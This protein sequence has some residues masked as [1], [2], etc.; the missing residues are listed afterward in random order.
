MATKPTP[1]NTPADDP[2]APALDITKIGTEKLHVPIVGL[3]PLIVSKF[4][5]K[6]KRKMLDSQQGRKAIKEIRNPDADF[7]A[8]MY[9]FNDGYGFPAVAFKLATV[10]AARLYGK[11]VTMRGLLQFMFFHGELS[12]VE[13]QVLVRLNGEPKMR[14]DYVRLAGPSRGADLRYRA[15]FRDWSA[16]L[17]ITYVKSALSRESMLSLLDAGGLTVGVGEW[18]PERKGDFG[19][20]TIDESRKVEVLP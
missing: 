7:E 3:T 4:S 2:G 8:S 18:R 10:S 15:E 11:D 5:E 16:T 17:S 20:Y 14:E 1:K 6:A 12:D 9:R 19:T 13:G